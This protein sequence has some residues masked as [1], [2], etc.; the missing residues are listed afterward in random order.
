MKEVLDQVGGTFYSEENWF[1]R[2]SDD[3]ILLFTYFQ[4]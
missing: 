3:W 4:P 1:K 2:Q